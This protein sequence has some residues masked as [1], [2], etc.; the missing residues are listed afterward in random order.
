M[1]LTSMIA[2]YDPRWSE[3]FEMERRKLAPIFGDRLQGIE[4]VG[5]TAVPMLSANPEIDILV[6][7]SDDADLDIY[8]A[9]MRELGYRRGGDLSPGHHFF[10][11]DM[12]GVRTH[13]V[14]VCISGHWQIVRLLSSAIC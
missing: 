6:E 7:I 5:S 12:D 8:S 13:K 10:K 9:R 2:F 1:A 4:H 3:Q 11:R 14:H